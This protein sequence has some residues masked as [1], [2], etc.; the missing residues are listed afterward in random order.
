MTAE[1][2]VITAYR[3]Y[4]SKIGL[5]EVG[6]GNVGHIDLVLVHLLLANYVETRSKLGW[7]GLAVGRCT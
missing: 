6:K 1:D 4:C 2:K 7:Q 5:V 3:G